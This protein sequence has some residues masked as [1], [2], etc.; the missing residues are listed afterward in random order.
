MLTVHATAGPSP[1]D[2]L[3]LIA[4][5]PI[6]AG[7]PIWVFRPGFDLAMAPAELAALSPWSRA[8]IS[9]FLYEEL[10]TGLFILCCDD[11]RYMNHSATPNTTTAL[12]QTTALCDIAAGDEL[13]CDYAEFDAATRRRTAQGFSSTPG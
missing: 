13:T 8:Q 10:E 9:R 6:P 11:A 7:T 12:R 2:G 3:G 4:R 1:I 5:S